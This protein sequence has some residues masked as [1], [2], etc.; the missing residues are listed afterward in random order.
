MHF[1]PTFY[2]GG[3]LPIAETPGCLIYTALS[4]IA[5]TS[6]PALPTASPV[7]PD[8]ADPQGLDYSL[9]SQTVQISNPALYPQ[10]SPYTSCRQ[11]PIGY[12]RPITATKF[13]FDTITQIAP[14]FSDA[15][16]ATVL[17]GS[18]TTLIP[19]VPQVP[20][21]PEQLSISTI[22][23][24]V[25]QTSKSSPPTSLPGGSSS[26]SILSHGSVATGSPTFGVGLPEPTPQSSKAGLESS[27]S[28]ETIKGSSSSKTSTGPK[29]TF[30]LSNDASLSAHNSSFLY[31]GLALAS[32]LLAGGMITAV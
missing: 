15:A 14:I 25:S 13:L 21:Q 24:T 23:I 9:I 1:D 11:K 27:N 8:A 10:Y 28:T 4:P 3:A 29:S 26:K 7:A 12:P 5:I 32:A 6:N 19:A 16:T 22:T 17:P 2:I 20:E 31:I 18:K 30:V